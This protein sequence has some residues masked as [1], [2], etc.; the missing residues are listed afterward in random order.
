MPELPLRNDGVTIACLVCECRFRPA[1]RRRF[2]SEACRQAAWRRRQPT[3]VPALPRHVA[4]TATVYLCPACDARFLGE[5][6][7]PDCGLFCRRL[8]PGGACPHCE[9][10]VTLADLLDSG[11]TNG[12]TLTR[13][14]STIT[15]TAPI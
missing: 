14:N 10:P 5:Q 2:C 13:A 4:R 6:R 8:G 7:C 9:E 15:D 3:P 11:A 1:G 12:P